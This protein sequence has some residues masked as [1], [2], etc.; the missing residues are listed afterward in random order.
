VPPTFDLHLLLW[1]V[2]P[3]VLA[4]LT[5]LCVALVALFRCDTKDIADTVRALSGISLVW[6]R[7]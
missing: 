4:H 1:L 5:F 7:K 3:L 2:A 6:R